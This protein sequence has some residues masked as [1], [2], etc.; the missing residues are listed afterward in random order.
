MKMIQ[1]FILL[2]SISSF[3]QSKVGTIDVDFII[4]KMP[5]IVNVQEQLDTYKKE[6]DL[7]FNK[8]MEVYNALI[9]DYTDNEVSF[10][11]AVKKQKQESF[12]V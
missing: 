3:A 1:L 9:K 6:L 2:I 4:S 12:R 10:T 8:N 7:D 11:I 5:E